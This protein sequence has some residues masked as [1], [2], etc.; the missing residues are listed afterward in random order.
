MTFSQIRTETHFDGKLLVLVLDQPQSYNSLTMQMLQELKYA[1]QEAGKNEQV[2]CIAIKGEGNAFCAG[3]NL[4]EAL[5]F[6]DIKNER[7]VQRFII[8]YYNPLVKEIAQSKKPIVA[9]VHGAAVGAG[10]SLATLCDFSLCSKSAYFSF[11][12]VK[13]GL[14]PDTAA[15]YYLP[16]LV[17]PQTARYLAFTGKK[18]DADHALRIGLTQEVFVQDEFEIKSM[19][20]LES[21]CNLP[22]K[23]IGLTKKAF[24]ESYENKLKEQLDVEGILQQVAAESEDFNE[25][26]NAFLNKRK[27]DFKGR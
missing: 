20:I 12:F 10:A 16:K 25:G 2:R 13:I 7:S 9:L 3:Q 23:A 18:I 24:H 17:G 8:E 5:S 6:G 26:V 21:L 11:A 19:E 27:P 22:T 4:K 1:V 15:T 14:I